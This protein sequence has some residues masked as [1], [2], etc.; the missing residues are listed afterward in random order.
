V[1]I[2]NETIQFVHHDLLETAQDRIRQLKQSAGMERTG[3]QAAFRF[4][5]RVD[6]SSAGI[7]PEE[8]IQRLEQIK[9]SGQGVHLGAV[10]ANLNMD[11]VRQLLNPA[12]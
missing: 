8:T 9:Q 11:R 7:S 6:D 1:K 4:R 5:G 2:D 12:S 3:D 10:H